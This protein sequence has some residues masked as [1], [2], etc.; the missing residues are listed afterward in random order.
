MSLNESP[1]SRNA[2]PQ[3]SLRANDNTIIQIHQPT[4]TNTI[5]IRI[6]RSTNLLRRSSIL[7]YLAAARSRDDVATVG[8][9]WIAKVA[10]VGFDG[11]LA[12]VGV[13]VGLYSGIGIIV[14]EEDA[15]SS[16]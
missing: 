2:S 1:R 13:D 5:S 16:Y 15:D 11:S 10:E 9:D 7:K 14:C 4:K 8:L 3:R 6:Q 12:A